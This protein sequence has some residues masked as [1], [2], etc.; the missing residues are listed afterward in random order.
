MRIVVLCL[1]PSRGGLE[2]YALEEIRQL[3]QRGHECFAVVTPGSYLQSVL[4]KEKISYATLTLSFKRLPL[5]A[6]RK[7]AL[8]LKEFN[9]DILHF[10][11]GKDLYLA[12]LAKFMAGEKVKLVHTRHM[13]YTRNK[14][15]IFHRWYYRQLNLLIAGTKLLQKLA[16]QYLVVDSDKIKVLYIGVAPPK[17][18]IPDCEQF[19]Q[20]AGFVRRKLNL[21]I[22]GRIEHGKGQHVLVEAMQILVANGYDISLTMIGHTMD[23]RYKE[24]LEQTIRQASLDKHIQFKSFV[25]NATECMP[26]FDVLVLTTYCEMFGLVLVEAMRAGV[27]VVGTDAGG[28]PEIIEHQVSGLLVKPGSAEDMQQKIEQLYKQPELLQRY[29]EN[30]KARADS[31]FSDE[32][33]YNELEKLLLDVIQ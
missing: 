23:A 2:L 30:G 11:W 28:V 33:H 5:F 31:I 7:L 3:T 22:F 9:A 32:L 24:K 17:G 1:S 25:E 21:A 16:R 29:A 26:C 13:H 12:S 14:K 15:D 8:I 6:A 27:A 4:E 18:S 19:Y 20:Q 10:H